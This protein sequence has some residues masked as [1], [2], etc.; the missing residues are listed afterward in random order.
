[1]FVKKP[2]NAAWRAYQ[3]VIG[4]LALSF[5]SIW[6][7]DLPKGPG[8]GAREMQRRCLGWDRWTPCPSFRGTDAGSR[9]DGVRTPTEWINTPNPYFAHLRLTDFEAGN[10]AQIAAFS[11]LESFL[12]AILYRLPMLGQ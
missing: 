6:Y 7:W 12:Q 4:Y 10:G 1:M 5:L 9:T 2:Q 3:I 11:Q 8:I